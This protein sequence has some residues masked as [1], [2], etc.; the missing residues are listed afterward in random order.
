MVV[1][2][3]NFQAVGQTEENV[4]TLQEC[5][6]YAEENS[7]TV[8]RNELGVDRNE[9]NLMQSR[10]QRYPTINSGG[11]YGYRWGRSIDPTS[12]LF[13]TQRI[14][15][16]GI[17]GNSSLL[18]FN[19]MQITNAIQQDKVNLEVSQY[20]LE[21]AK[22][23]VALDVTTF[24][25]DVILNKELLN[26]SQLQ[27]ETTQAQMDRTEKLVDAGSLPIS[28]LLDL[29]A[30][31]ASNEAEVIN[32]ENALNISLLNLQQIMQL[33][34]DE[35]FDVLVPDIDI[36][37]VTIESLSVNEVYQEALTHLPVIKSA[38][39]SVQSSEI[40]IQLAQGG[41][42]PSL[43]LNGNLFTNYS[44]AAPGPRIPDETQSREQII[45]YITGDP[46]TT[47]STI[48]PGFTSDPN[49]GWFEQ[50]EDNLSKALTLNLSV[51]IFN[52][53]NVRS[54]VQ[55]AKIT[56]LEAEINQQEVKNQLRQNIER[57]FYDARAAAKTYASALVQVEAL[58]ESFRSI[59][60]RYNIGAVN[61]VDYQIA[62]NNLFQA[63]SDLLRSKYS[64]IF[65]E[66]ILD[67]YMG[68]PLI[69]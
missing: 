19:G 8:K 44:D 18:L 62:N 61:F 69:F 36:D 10:A 28:D 38:S 25:L 60:K 54:N 16:A 13:V 40:G 37:N 2:G 58:E 12:N 43:S 24:Y 50:F 59:E 32:A 4:W 55:R 30:Q 53:F 27:L 49:Y 1:F 68:K 67:F 9:V 48:I 56:Q 26:N 45:G 21:A 34:A 31:L 64:F 23:N 6:E 41:Y 33:P 52:G 17:S 22:D 14:A 7:L 20:D 65:R 63:R 15:S 47:V 42:Y 29:R 11:Q 35:E 39:L 57:S 51:P 3:W 46:S 5:V 66:K